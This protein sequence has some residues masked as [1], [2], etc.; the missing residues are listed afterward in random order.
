MET[1]VKTTKIMPEDEV[2]PNN[3]DFQQLL[4]R[5]VAEKQANLAHFCQ[6]PPQNVQVSVQSD[7]SFAAMLDFST[8]EELKILNCKIVG[9]DMIF[10]LASGIYKR[11]GNVL[12]GL[13]LSAPGIAVE[14]LNQIKRILMD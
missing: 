4:S 10:S 3:I 8:A 1:T 14:S 2:C 13:E 12:V 5:T 11:S 6:I 9:G 7:G